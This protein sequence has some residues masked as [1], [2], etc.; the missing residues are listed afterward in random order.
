M[1]KVRHAKIL[2]GLPDTYGRGRIVGDYRRVALYGLDY[3]IEEKK[4]DK[5]NCGC[6]QMTDDVIPVSYTHL[7]VY[8]RQILRRK[9]TGF[10]M[11]IMWIATCLSLLIRSRFAV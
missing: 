3:L 9:I 8:K 11:R 5:T 6:G 4:K 10:H 2:T 1:M 7:D